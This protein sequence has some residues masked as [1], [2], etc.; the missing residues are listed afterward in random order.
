MTDGPVF[1]RQVPE[2]PDFRLA[3]HT[4]P[5]GNTAGYE[6]MGYVA[7]ERFITK[8]PRHTE[9]TML[10]REVFVLSNFKLRTA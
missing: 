5:K 8:I 4:V 9:I 3:D 10:F 7:C 2:Q 6:Y 1:V